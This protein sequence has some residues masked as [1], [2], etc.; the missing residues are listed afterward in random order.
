M[1]AAPNGGDRGVAGPLHPKGMGPR[2]EERRGNAA[3][4]ACPGG[5]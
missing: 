5:G 1:G 4:A 3:E 2:A